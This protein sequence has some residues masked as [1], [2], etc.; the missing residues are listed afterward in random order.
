MEKEL[1]NEC[2]N[3]DTESQ[4][5]FERDS[6]DEFFKNH[7]IKETFYRMGLKT[8][9]NFM[10][11]GAKRPISFANGECYYWRP[12]GRNINNGYWS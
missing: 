2:V 1:E 3:R 11:R 9:S 4:L 7:V 8:H 12:T 6:W 5:V 10:I